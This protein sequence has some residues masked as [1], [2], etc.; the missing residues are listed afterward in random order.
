MTQGTSGSSWSSAS[1]APAI[2][3]RTRSPSDWI[4]GGNRSLLSAVVDIYAHSAEEVDMWRVP[5]V[6]AALILVACSGPTT[7]ETETKSGGLEQDPETV[8]G[9]LDVGADFKTWK[10]VNTAPWKS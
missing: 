6:F 9:P 7:K 8:F 5:V 4:P 10:K 2:P 3:T 1:I